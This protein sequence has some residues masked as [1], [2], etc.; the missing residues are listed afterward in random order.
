V[1]WSPR[2]NAYIEASRK[3]E[4]LAKGVAGDGGHQALPAAERDKALQLLARA[5]GAIDDGLP[6]ADVAALITAAEAHI[7]SVR[8]KV[9][10]LLTKLDASTAA[11]L[12]RTGKALKK[13]YTERAKELRRAISAGRSASITDATADLNAL[14]ADIERWKTANTRFAG[15]DESVQAQR[16]AA[17]DAAA[18]LAAYE[19]AVDGSTPPPGDPA[20]VAAAEPTTK[21]PTVKVT[22]LPRLRRLER[23]VWGVTLLFILALGWITLYLAADTFGADAKD[24]LAVFLW[25]TVTSGVFGKA[26]GFGEL[27]MLAFPSG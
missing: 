3:I 10:E 9:E 2:G 19:T 7:S 4:G 5:A 18:T 1:P 13:V 23:L 14:D 25:G 12:A 8:V 6:P 27:K 15:L 17:V 21:E 11:I 24:Y 16:L 20:H 26:V 22:T